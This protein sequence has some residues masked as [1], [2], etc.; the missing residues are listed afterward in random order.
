M[1]S[2]TSAGAK[3]GY[4]RKAKGALTVEDRPASNLKVLASAVGGGKPLQV[5]CPHYCFV[6]NP[7]QSPSRTLPEQFPGLLEGARPLSWPGWA[8]DPIGPRLGVAA[9]LSINAYILG[10]YW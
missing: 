1:S 10:D 5:G 9:R 3:Q 4:G 8:G 6:A 7:L 2:P